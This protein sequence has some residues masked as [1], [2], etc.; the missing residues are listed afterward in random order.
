MVSKQHGV[1]AHVDELSMITETE[2]GV[3]LEQQQQKNS[4]ILLIIQ[5][6]ISNFHPRHASKTSPRQT[7]L[8][9]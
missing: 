1:L 8:P 4:P 6:S 5:T 3:P 2:T 9:I 7:V